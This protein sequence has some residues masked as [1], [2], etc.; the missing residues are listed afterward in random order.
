MQ[1]YTEEKWWQLSD[2]FLDEATASAMGAHLR[3]CPRCAALWRDLRA[4]ESGLHELAPVA[5]HGNA[6]AVRAVGT[7]LWRRA[8][9]RTVQVAALAAGIAA[10]VLL[11]PMLMRATQ[12]DTGNVVRRGP[13]APV[14]ADGTTKA[15]TEDRAAPAVVVG[16]QVELAWGTVSRITEPA[17]LRI[18]TNE[19][20]AFRARLARGSAHFEVDPAAGVSVAVETPDAVVEVVGTAFSVSVEDEGDVR[21]HVT[22]ERGRVRVARAGG[23]DVVFVGAGE[24]FPSE[25]PEATPVPE[26]SRAGGRVGDMPPSDAQ[27]KKPSDTQTTQPDAGTVDMPGSTPRGQ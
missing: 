6:L 19:P 21:T 16:E 24:S 23:G 8:A 17:A 3:A 20:A 22:V 18:L 7:Y 2:G 13:V 5:E 14:S 27:A 25:P 1:C 11:L 10:A 15:P 26:P 4:L 9:R 12:P